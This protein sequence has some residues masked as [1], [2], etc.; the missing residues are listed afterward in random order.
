[1]KTRGT[2]FVLAGA[3]ALATGLNILDYGDSSWDLPTILI[4][5]ALTL[6]LLVAALRTKSET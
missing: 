1:V 4:E 3:L 5:G 6:Y 2:Y